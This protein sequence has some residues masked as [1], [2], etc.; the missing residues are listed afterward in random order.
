M[1]L[2]SGGSYWRKELDWDERGCT[3]RRDGAEADGQGVQ[4]RKM[5]GQGKETVAREWRRGQNNLV[6]DLAKRH[7]L[8]IRFLSHSGEVTVNRLFPKNDLSLPSSA[9]T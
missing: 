6:R 2:Y 9:D 1:N 3:E 7:G 4:K 8:R 5:L